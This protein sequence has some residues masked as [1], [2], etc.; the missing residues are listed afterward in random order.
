MGR[1]WARLLDAHPDVSLAAWVDL[2]VAKVDEACS[3]TG[4]DV[5]MRLAGMREALDARPDF[6]VD[7]SIP[8]AHRDV[9]L[10]ALDAGVPVLG[11]KPM[12]SSMTEAKEMVRASERAGKL[13]MVS[14][15]RRYH[16]GLTALR[17]LIDNRL[18]DLGVLNADFYLGPHFGGFRDQMASPLLLDMAIHTFDAARYLSGADPVSVYAEEFN[19][20]WSW[21]S[22]N[23]CASA[24]FEMSN[25]LRFSYRGSWCAEGLMTSWESEWRAVGS[26]GTAKWDGVGDPVAEVASGRDGFIRT[27]DTFE[28]G[29]DSI[30]EGIQGSLNEFMNCLKSGAVPQGECHDNIKSLAMVFGAIESSRT[31]RRIQICDL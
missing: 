27:V 11:E 19:P 1:V 10:V 17:R 18:G 29:R 6:L 14:Q 8:E 26:R 30:L 13:Y 15:S 9:T 3:E 25:G 16:G 21:Y 28:E 31:G 24:L 12:A 23:A 22:G 5:P 4:I 20:D 7:V 2:N